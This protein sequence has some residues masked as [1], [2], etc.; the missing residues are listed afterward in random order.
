MSSAL[1]L[2]IAVQMIFQFLYFSETDFPFYYMEV[3]Q[4]AFVLQ[5]LSSCVGFLKDRMR[6][7]Q[8]NNVN[9]SKIEWLYMTNMCQSC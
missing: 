3:K 9:S 8:G 4:E 2:A 7:L 5:F 1:R 6:H